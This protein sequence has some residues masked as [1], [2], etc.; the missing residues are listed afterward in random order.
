MST[1]VKEPKQ[2][3]AKRDVALLDEGAQSPSL[4]EAHFPFSGIHDRLTEYRKILCR[5]L[6]QRG[7]D[8]ASFKG[9]GIESLLGEVAAQIA[10]KIETAIAAC[11]PKELSKLKQAISK[12]TDLDGDKLLSGVSLSNRSEDDLRSTSFEEWRARIDGEIRT[13]MVIGDASE[14]GIKDSLA[15]ILRSD[16]L[17]KMLLC[18][19]KGYQWASAQHKNSA[20]HT[21]SSQHS[22]APAGTTE[23]IKQH[24]LTA[25]TTATLG[26][27]QKSI[28]AGTISR[29]LR[30]VSH[31]A[32]PH[33]APELGTFQTVMH[34]IASRLLAAAK[35]DLKGISLTPQ[36][37]MLCGDGVFAAAIETASCEIFFSRRF[38]EDLLS[39]PEMCE[40]T[41]SIDALAAVIAHELSH[42]AFRQRVNNTP[43][44]SM[45]QEQWCDFRA[46][47]M[48]EGAGFK[49]KAMTLMLAM[50]ERTSG[51]G[52]LQILDINDVH[53]SIPIRSELYEKVSFES[54]ERDRRK[55]AVQGL[56]GETLPRYEWR[57]RLQGVVE[58]TAGLAVV[59]PINFELQSRLPGAAG[60]RQVVAALAEICSEYRDLLRY[61]AAT[62][63]LND[64]CTKLVKVLR[65]K[66]VPREEFR[67]SPELEQISETLWH[68]EERASASWLY[69][70]V[71][72]A[73]REGEA[74]APQGW[75]LF[76]GLDAKVLRFVTASS[77]QE[78]TEA[79]RELGSAFEAAD[80]RDVRLTA[81][82]PRWLDVIYPSLR[83][84]V[85]AAFKKEDFDALFKGAAIPLPFAPHLKLQSELQAGLESR[86]DSYADYKQLSDLMRVYGITDAI[87][88]LLSKGFEHPVCK[89]LR[90]GAGVDCLDAFSISEASGIALEYPRRLRPYERDDAGTN[91][92]LATGAWVATEQ[93]FALFQARRAQGILEGLATADNVN[94]AELRTLFRKHCELIAPQVYPVGAAD[95]PEL[96]ASHAFARRFVEMLSEAAKAASAA[97]YE[98]A[99]VREILL[100]SAL[101]LYDKSKN[102]YCTYLCEVR[103]HWQGPRVDPEHP[104]VRY[105]QLDPDRLFT[106]AE[107]L[108]VVVGLNG[109]DKAPLSSWQAASTLQVL[110]QCLGSEEQLQMLLGVN[111]TLA[112]EAFAENLTRVPNLFFGFITTVAYANGQALIEARSSY[113]VDYLRTTKPEH[114]SLAALHTLADLCGRVCGWQA[115]D[116][117]LKATEAALSKQPPIA[118]LESSVLLDRY[119]R[120]VAMGAID[121]SPDL[122]ESLHRELERRYDALSSHPARQELVKDLLRPRFFES[123]DYGYFLLPATVSDMHFS[124]A[125]PRP[126]SAY[127][128]RMSDPRFEQFLVRSSA[129]CFV[130]SVREATGAQHDDG[131]K[132]FREQVETVVS[133]LDK[134]RIPTVLRAQILQ[135]LADELLTQA[136]LSMYLRSQLGAI[137]ALQDR[138]RADQII[139]AAHSHPLALNAAAVQVHNALLYLRNSASSRLRGKMLEFLIMCAPSEEDKRELASELVI[140]GDALMLK[141]AMG[142]GADERFL[143]RK[144][145]V[146]FHLMALHQRFSQLDIRAKGALLAT[147]ATDSDSPTAADFSKF[148][149]KR[150]FPAVLAGVGKWEELLKAAINYYFEFYGGSIHQKFMVACSILAGT[151]SGT[152]GEGDLASVGRIA[153]LF[154]GAHGPAGYKMLQRL[155]NYPD[156]P[157]AIKD[158]LCDVLDNTV[159]YPRWTIHEMIAKYGPPSAVKRWVGRAKAGSMCLSVELKDG[160]K[161]RYISIIHPGAHVDSQYWLGNFAIMGSKLGELDKR[162]SLLAPMASQAKALLT[163]E[164]EF[165]NAPREQQKVAEQGYTYQMRFPHSGLTVHSKCAALL[166]SEAKLDE[167]FMKSSGYKEVQTAVGRPLLELIADFRQR[168]ASGELHS[169]EQDRQFSVL[170]AAAFAVVSNEIRLMLA[171]RGKDH[172][173]HPGNYLI[174]IA[175]GPQPEVRLTHFDFGGTDI[176][177]PSPEA[178]SEL[179]ELLR[180]FVSPLGLLKAA[181]WPNATADSLCRKLFKSVHWS[182]LPPGLNASLG[183]NEVIDFHTGKRQLLSQ[184]DLLRAFKVALDSGD[185][186]PEL[187]ELAPRGIFGLVVR[188]ALKLV[189]VSGAHFLKRAVV[190]TRSVEVAQTASPSEH[191]Q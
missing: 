114:F 157:Q 1:G 169:D 102:I 56:A 44:N 45:V 103:E 24:S 164:C 98:R 69:Y 54:F 110:S 189:D 154:L 187:S 76:A 90:N 37:F 176:A 186:A 63:L 183:A 77:G 140:S 78:V 148:N 118:A 73:R 84:A 135:Q 141:I 150:L 139:S 163:N 178:R 188:G 59:S 151:G 80:K 27:L 132:E 85:G 123:G 11:P 134:S 143:S 4:S 177:H 48:M 142:D 133:F 125:K 41:M 127:T 129:E 95:L 81:G 67:T 153:R 13:R 146:A 152:Q 92:V 113:I 112:P 18:D 66:G 38:M 119:Q 70:K 180:P 49:P 185:V 39:A 162:L 170:Q 3:A 136:P 111:T 34:E 65:E 117:V 122:Q 166:A 62:P 25:T 88:A 30:H 23:D 7:A 14:K 12:A 104:L 94:C 107:R 79:M 52:G 100:E 105:V 15:G 86:P 17:R 145:V 20:Q 42:V 61:S 29:D 97:D 51:S 179:R 75:G 108:M 60:P 147:L 57:Q 131:S 46:A 68:S 182:S 109:L 47:A 158:E 53:A 190:P 175:D 16:D 126:S 2:V 28:G 99:V 35:D 165:A 64:I 184:Q 121:R 137:G 96:R 32:F 36:H 93:Q 173:R 26:E 22:E 159:K 167:D 8:P 33:S 89:S 124:E 101:G 5:E 156:T 10:Q 71:L 87:K 9:Q 130:T 116:A 161:S 171:G 106:P 31:S 160:A 40:G 43:G 6:T 144:P 21:E 55:E 115:L 128:V 50:V 149:E 120:L 138:S 74:F 19:L 58:Q 91:V 191:L 83:E 168:S 172:D 181:L 72:D 155:R 174:E 82:G